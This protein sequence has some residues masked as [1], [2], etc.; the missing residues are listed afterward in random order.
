MY[1]ML[2]GYHGN[3]RIL[4]VW[5]AIEQLHVLYGWTQAWLQPQHW[6]AHRSRE[7]ALASKCNSNT[8]I[9]PYVGKQLL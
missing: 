7:S 4:K 6:N 3:D 2:S 9:K 8:Q 5:I 1:V